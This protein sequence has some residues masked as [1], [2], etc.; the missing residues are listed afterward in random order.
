MSNPRRN[1]SRLRFFKYRATIERTLTKTTSEVI[2]TDFP[3]AFRPATGGAPD[4]MQTEAEV[5]DTVL[6][7]G[8]PN[9]VNANCLLTLTHV[10][11][12]RKSF[13]KIDNV[14]AADNDEATMI[15]A[16]SPR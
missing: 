11:S 8:Y 7:L 12:G 1:S 5:S 3:A 4:L 6:L 2:V 15:L 14:S 9:N 13:H 10:E 16:V